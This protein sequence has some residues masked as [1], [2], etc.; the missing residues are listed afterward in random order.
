MTYMSCN[1]HLFSHIERYFLIFIW[2]HTATRQHDP[3]HGPSHCLTSTGGICDAVEAHSSYCAS[4][5]VMPQPLH[6]KHWQPVGGRRAE[7]A[8]VRGQHCHVSHKKYIS[9]KVQPPFLNY[10]AQTFHIMAKKR[11]IW[12]ICGEAGWLNNG[13]QR[14]P[15]N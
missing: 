11:P 5:A 4:D 15:S 9:T 1:S 8:R 12:Y 6:F 3:P 7:E 14:Y 2:W 10:H 13:Q